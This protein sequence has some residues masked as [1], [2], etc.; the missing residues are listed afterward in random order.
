MKKIFKYIGAFFWAMWLR[1]E[2]IY[3]GRFKRP[4]KDK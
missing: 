1:V 3:N 2:D 4:K